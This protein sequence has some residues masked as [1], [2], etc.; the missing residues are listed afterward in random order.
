[1]LEQL[2]NHFRKFDWLLLAAVLFLALLGL[3]EIYS[4][5][6]GQGGSSVLNFRKQALFIG[7]GVIAL[8]GF[9]LIDYNFYK[10]IHRYLYLAG[11]GLLGVVLVFGQTIKGTKGWFSLLGLGIQPVEFV[12]L[13]LIIFLARMFANASVKTRPLKYFL[14]SGSAAG[15]LAFLVLLQPDFG[16]AMILMV[17]WLLLLFFFGFD[18][19][20]FVMIA[21]SAVVVFAIAW[22]FVFQDYQKQRIITFVNPTYDSLNQGYNISQ[23]MIAVGSGGLTG[24]GLGFGSQSQLKFLPEAHTDFIFAVVAEEF[25]LVGVLFFLGFYLLLFIRAIACLRNLK[26]DF[27]MFI[28][29]GGVGLLFVEMFINVG[30]NVGLMPV[31]GI[32]LPFVSYGGSSILASF[33]LIGIIEGIIIKSRSRY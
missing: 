6:L 22:A 29:L 21:I 30:M 24:R 5:S 23:A 14:L 15:I 11:A 17:I 7:L 20:Y 1:M 28:V 25:G 27:A 16:A 4:I 2:K 13:I 8:L 31:V 12:K 9:S 19:K 33:V 32:A 18:R 26:D 3:L 10:S